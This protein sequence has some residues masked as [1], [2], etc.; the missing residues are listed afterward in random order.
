MKFEPQHFELGESYKTPFDNLITINKV[1]R[2]TITIYDKWRVNNDEKREKIVETHIMTAE[3]YYYIEKRL[4]EV[5]QKLAI[6][7]HP[8]K[9]NSWGFSI[10]Y[11]NSETKNEF[12]KKPIW[13][14]FS[15]NVPKAM[16]IELYKDYTAYLRTSK[17]PQ[18]KENFRS[19]YGG[20]MI[21]LSID[22][23]LTE[24]TIEE[25]M[26]DLLKIKLVV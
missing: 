25:I 26:N 24:N 2:A 11:Q 17:L 23:Y 20:K 3:L 7:T 9:E 10:N 18:K 12:E 1:N 6:T 13:I 14:Y 4:F 21:Y 5:N 16:R 22:E 15:G 8:A 19:Y